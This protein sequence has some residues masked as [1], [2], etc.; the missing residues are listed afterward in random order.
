MDAGRDP[1]ER[2]KELRAAI[3][4][5]LD[6][7]GRRWRVARLEAVTRRGGLAAAAGFVGGLV[8]RVRHPQAPPERSDRA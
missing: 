6:E 2:L 4:A 7:L 5:D 3:G 8:R 1:Q